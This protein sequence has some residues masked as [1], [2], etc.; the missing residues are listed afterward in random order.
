[1]NEFINLDQVSE[2]NPGVYWVD[3]GTK[4]LMS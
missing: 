4:T 1:M 2:I 3:A